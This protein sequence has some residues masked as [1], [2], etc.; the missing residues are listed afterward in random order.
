VHPSANA[1]I[2]AAAAVAASHAAQSISDVELQRF[3]FG[4]RFPL[5]CSDATVAANAYRAR[6]T[7]D[8]LRLHDVAQTYRAC[9]TGPY[10]LGSDAVRNHANFN[11]AAALLLAARYE[12]APEATR[13][14]TAAQTL[15]REIAGYARPSGPRTPRYDNNAPSPYRTDAGRIARD[16]AAI[17]NVTTSA[18]TAQ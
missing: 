16:A 2:L 18:G 10:G 4:G 11:A 3:I 17:L 7:T 9:A 5:G 6:A 13:D 15:A 14:A 12:A 8:P 1:L